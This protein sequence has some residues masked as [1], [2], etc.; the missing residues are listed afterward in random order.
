MVRGDGRASGRPALAHPEARRDAGRR[1]RLRE[2]GDDGGAPRRSEPGPGGQ[3]R[4]PAGDRGRLLRHARHP[5]GLRLPDRRRGGDGRRGGRGLAGRRRL[6]HQLRRPPAAL[7]ARHRRGPAAPARPGGA[8][9]PERSHRRGRRAARSQ[10]VAPGAR[11]RGGARR[12]LGGGARAGSGER[13]RV[14]GGGRRAAGRRSRGGLGA[15]LRARRR[16]ARLARLR[17]PLR[18]DPVRRRGLRRGGGRRVRPGARRSHGDDPQRLARL[19][20]PG[21]HRL[22]QGDGGGGAALRHR[23]PRPPALLR[24][25][26]LAR[27]GAA[28]SRRWPRP[29]TSPSPTAR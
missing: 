10:A 11:A 20:P 3:R 14:A 19:R 4:P 15:R 29:P 13:P 5:L 22:S 1:H 17:Q 18:R 2:R 24:A 25:A 21:L 26:A 28:T 6:R 16:T 8:P 9:V 23:A 12:A 27:K 7:A